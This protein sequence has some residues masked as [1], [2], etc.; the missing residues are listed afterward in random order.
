[1]AYS[2]RLLTVLVQ[3]CVGQSEFVWYVR[4]LRTRCNAGRIDVKALCASIGFEKMEEYLGLDEGL[5][6]VGPLMIALAGCVYGRQAPR[7]KVMAQELFAALIDIVACAVELGRVPALTENLAALGALH[8]AGVRPRRISSARKRALTAVADDC[9][10]VGTAVGGLC[11]GGNIGCSARQEGNLPWEICSPFRAR[12][13][14]PVLAGWAARV[15]WRSHSAHG[16]RRREGLGRRL[17]VFYAVGRR[18]AHGCVVPAGG[19]CE[20]PETHHIP[21]WTT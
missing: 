1:M 16:H 12:R 3:E 17:A 11:C 14:V 4:G 13:D 18:E 8:L 21:P 6:K 20:M 15:A 2:E 10:G 7:F 5:C 19:P 9:H